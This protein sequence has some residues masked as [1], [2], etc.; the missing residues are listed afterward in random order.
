MEQRTPA[1]GCGVAITDTSST[2]TWHSKESCF[3]EHPELRDKAKQKGS[4][5]QPPAYMMNLVEQ[6]MKF[7]DG[8]S[9]SAPTDS[10]GKENNLKNKILTIENKNRLII[11]EEKLKNLDRISFRKIC[12]NKI[13]SRLELDEREKRSIRL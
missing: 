11:G 2:V 3:A 10:S 7:A 12:L 9:A 5:S 1:L 8:K 13:N 6:F 4:S